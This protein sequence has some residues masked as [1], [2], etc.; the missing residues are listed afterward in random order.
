MLIPANLRPVAVAKQVRRNVR[1]A[2]RL[3]RMERESWPGRPHPSMWRRGFVSS[4]LYSFPDIENPSV[5]L[6]SDLRFLMHFSSLNPPWARVLLDD[7]NVFADALTARGLGTYAPEVYGIVSA[8]GLLVRSAAAHERLM[9]QTAVVLKPTTGRGGTGVRIVSPAEVEAMVPRFGTALLVQERVTQHP[10]LLRINPLALNT[11]RVLAVRPPTGPVLAVATH[12]W[13]TTR[14]GAVDNVS[15]GGLESVVDLATG[16]LGPAIRLTQDG[17]RVEF[18]RHP[19]TDAQ[20]T[21]VL[22]PHWSAVRDLTLNL[23]ES[24]PELEHV[25]WDLAV[26]DQGP[27]VIEGNGTRPAVPAMQVHGSFLD[28][29]A[30]RDYYTNK[31]LLPSAR[32]R[33]GGVSTGP[34][35]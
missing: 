5:P 3:I 9:K 4:R 19:D 8:E 17:R 20:I 22:V 6:V 1:T 14:S 2:T 33:V 35:C 10:A 18:D 27:R 16:R 7:K 11:L 21:G 24:F 29:P 32:P 28:D 31:G 34:R 25:G 15:A 30:L 13:G 26:S 12:K 23:M